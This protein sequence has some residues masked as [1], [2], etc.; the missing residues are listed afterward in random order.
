MPTRTSGAA[1]PRSSLPRRGRPA[2]DLPLDR[3]LDATSA[4][5]CLA[6]KGAA[7]EILVRSDLR[8]AVIRVPMVLG[9]G[10]YASKALYDRAVKRWS[11]TFRA[12]S[13]EQPVYAGDVVEAIVR[14]GKLELDD[15]FDLGGPEVLT[16]REMT[17]RAAAKLN[18]STRVLSLPIGLGMLIA[19]VLAKVSANP[20]MTPAM[21]G[22]L[23]HDDDVDAGMAL[24][25]LGLAALTPVDEMLERVLRPD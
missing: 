24:E 17:R 22:V 21:L 2:R 18:R 8:T 10:D 20:P 13:L 14:A 9:E 25:R 16:R 11:F 15:A 7:E 5:E 1:K 19:W 6:S 23:D 4:N 12:S 3:R